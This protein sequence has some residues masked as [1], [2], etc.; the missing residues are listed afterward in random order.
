[1]TGVWFKETW[2]VLN[3][4]PALWW[5][6]ILFALFTGLVL[7]GDTATAMMLGW[8]LHTAVTA[9]WIQQ[10]RRALADTPPTWSDFLEG[11]GRYFNPLLVGQLVLATLWV[12]VAA[13]CLYGAY[14]V[15]G[16]PL[17]GFLQL[18]DLESVKTWLQQFSQAQVMTYLLF[19]SLFFVFWALT[20]WYTLLWQPFAVLANLSWWQAFRHSYHT[21]VA[22]GWQFLLVLVA[23]FSILALVAQLTF[24]G[25]PILA[26][27]GFLGQVV[28]TTFFT[29]L[30]AWVV[31]RELLS[32]P[33]TEE[34]NLS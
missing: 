11:V 12:T 33:P 21:V 16:G 25:G 15:A 24:A 28:W 17:S 10:M 30:Y 34:Q 2:R 1:M 3:T 26:A 20:S 18:T 13:L 19:G 14:Q 22:A 9:G 31:N 27:I 8:L 29:L 6:P 4:T 32:N 23:Q 7:P 5:P